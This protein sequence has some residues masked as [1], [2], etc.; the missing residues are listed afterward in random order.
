MPREQLPPRLEKTDGSP[1][2]YILWNDGKPRRLSCGTEDLIQAEAKLEDFLRR[3]GEATQQLRRPDQITI[4]EALALYLLKLEGTSSA[5]PAANSVKA[6]MGWWKEST[7]D[8]ITE[9][10]AKGYAA[11]RRVQPTR[12]KTKLKSDW[13]IHGD[14]S[15]LRSSVNSMFKAG[16]LTRAPFVPVPP[17]P[18]GKDV[19]F[20]HYEAELLIESC[21]EDHIRLFTEL[22]L[23]TGG[24][25]SAL[26]GMKWVGQIHFDR[27][28]LFLNPP[29]R[30]QT[31]KFNA[32]LPMNGHIYQVLLIAQQ[33][34]RSPYVVEYFRYQRKLEAD[35][36]LGR[37]LPAPGDGKVGTVKAGFAAACRRARKSSLERARKAPRKSVDRQR[38][39]EAAAKFKRAT[40]HT[41]RHT[42]GTWM[43]QGGVDLWKIAGWLGH[44]V[45]RTTELYAHH[46]PDYLTDAADALEARAAQKNRLQLAIYRSPATANRGFGRLEA[47]AAS[48]D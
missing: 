34:A 2:W 4:N 12:R 32:A 21:V 19:W 11:W 25:H 41:L 1:N 22:G 43:A 14:L 35:P 40:P 27:R 20:E 24:R 48:R 36:E 18:D 39:R 45:E 44:S 15:V 17:A 28:R 33:R 46:H 7:I 6:L 47:E 42:A 26:L 30:K 8:A 23:H 37:R 5:R 10:S 38:W 13:T 29:G 3:K 31:S 9:Q 16:K